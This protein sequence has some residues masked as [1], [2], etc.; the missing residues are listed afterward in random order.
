MVRVEH[1]GTPTL[2]TL[3]FL[4]CHQRPSTVFTEPFLI[5]EKKNKNFSKLNRDMSIEFRFLPCKI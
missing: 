2:V 5:L 3:S 1:R 4:L